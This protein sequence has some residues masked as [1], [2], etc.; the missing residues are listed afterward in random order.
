MNENDSG[1]QQRIFLC[2]FSGEN[3]ILQRRVYA[4]YVDLK[5]RLPK[6]TN[7]LFGGSLVRQSSPRSQLQ[8]FPIP[9][10]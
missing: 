7:Y 5:E 1:Q 2:Q 10:I 6:V 3:L 4:I 8:R 9:G